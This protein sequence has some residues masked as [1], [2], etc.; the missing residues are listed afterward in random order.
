MGCYAAYVVKKM[1]HYATVCCCYQGTV[2]LLGSFFFC[3]SKPRFVHN[4][5]VTF[6]YQKYCNSCVFVSSTTRFI[7]K[8]S[9][10]IC[11]SCGT[12]TMCGVDNGVPQLQQT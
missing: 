4:V 5:N 9:D 8:D 12:A 3:K 6:T 7:Q 2:A 10:N 11:G 1:M